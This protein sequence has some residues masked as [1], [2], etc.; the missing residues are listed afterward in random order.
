MVHTF[1]QGQTEQVFSFGLGF[2]SHFL[3]NNSSP[4]FMIL[5]LALLALS[6]DLRVVNSPCTLSCVMVW[7]LFTFACTSKCQEMRCHLN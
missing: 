2:S 6:R 4:I 3:V 1:A 7:A 5:G